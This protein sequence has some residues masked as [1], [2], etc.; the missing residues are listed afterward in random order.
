ME[1]LHQGDIVLVERIKDPVL[2]VSKDYFNLS[3][4]IIG[5]VIFKNYTASPL[6]YYIEADEFHGY[7]QC[8]KMALLDLNVRGYKKI[9]RIQMLDRMEISDIIQGVFDYV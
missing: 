1:K 3:G 4:E 9:G 5:C 6:H 8:E 7:V 2:V